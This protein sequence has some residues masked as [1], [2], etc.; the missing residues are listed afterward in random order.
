MDWRKCLVSLAWCAS[1][2]LA[3]ATEVNTATEAELD[4]ILGIGP[5]MSQRILQERQLGPFTDWRDLMRRVSGIG[6]KKSTQFSNQGLTVNGQPFV[7][8][9]PAQPP[10]PNNG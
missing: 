2:S 4:S 8:P 3:A 7:P 6:Q 1:A 10:T 5:A 9:A